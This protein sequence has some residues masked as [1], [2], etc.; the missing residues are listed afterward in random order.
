MLQRDYLIVGA[1]VA[2]ASACQ[3]I[4]KYDKKGSILVIGNEGFLPYD[5]QPLTRDF[6]QKSRYKIEDLQ[7]FAQSWYDRNKIELRLGAIA[8]QFNV[9]RR[10][11]VLDTGQTVEFKKALLATGSRPRKPSVAGANLGNIIYLRTVRDAM[12]LREI[13]DTEKQIVVIGGG[14]IAM[15]TSATL[16]R[17]GC[18]VTLMC[19][20]STLWEKLVDRDTSKW[21]TGFMETKGVTLMMQES[22]N[23][24]EG[25]TVLKNIQTKSGERFPAAVAIVAIGSEL[26]LRLV[27]NT[28]LG[29][30]NGTPVTNTLE[31]EEKGIFAAGDVALYPDPHFGSVRRAPYYQNAVEQGIIAG[32]NMTGKKRQRYEVLPQYSCKFFDL[33]FD[34]IGDF[35]FAPQTI[36][37]EGDRSKKD[38][39]AKYYQGDKLTGVLLCNKPPQML[40]QAVTEFKKISKK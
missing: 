34:F 21:L 31:T 4:R 30:P 18:K 17:A 5:R 13:M 2:A 26:N 1:G 20:D 11:A 8:T 37:F 32:M 33:H 6:L 27:Q 12:A 23:G 36:E 19:R 9:E 28:P 40:A 25:K 39:V 29:S 15:E 24:F 35:S 3:S 16:T 22:I 7:V 14:L 10:L 38:F